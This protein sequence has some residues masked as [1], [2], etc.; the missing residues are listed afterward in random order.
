[1]KKDKKNILILILLIIV[2]VFI[3]YLVFFSGI[4]NKLKANVQ[5]LN[6]TV[7]KNANA[8]D[9]PIVDSVINSSGENLVNTDVSII[10]TASSKYN[11]TKVE[12]SFDLNSWKK[13]KGNYNDKQITTKLVF[14]NNMNN[15]VYIRVE[16]ENGYKSYAYKT[17]VMIDKESPNIIVGKKDND[18]VIKA[19]DNN[20]IASIQYSSN[21]LSWEDENVSGES[22]V[23]TKKLSNGTYVRA[24][25]SAG[26]VSNI[27]KVD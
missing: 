20:S 25:D 7:N 18:V 14:R 4:T 24:V 6:A 15:E 17:K 27:K 8:S 10:I 19:K 1:M 22:V 26:N 16:N 11:I 13:V 12:Y 2:V 9:L 21:K 5:S 23:L 3:S